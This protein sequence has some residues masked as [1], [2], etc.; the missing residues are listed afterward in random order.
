MFHVRISPQQRI[1]EC[2]EPGEVELSRQAR[3]LQRHARNGVEYV[4][5]MQQLLHLFSDAYRVTYRFE[6]ALRLCQD[7]AQYPGYRLLLDER[8]R[9]LKHQFSAAKCF[10][11][12]Y[13]L[14][15]QLRVERS[16]EVR[17]HLRL[18]ESLCLHRQLAYHSRGIDH[19]Q[20]CIELRRA[21]I[22]DQAEWAANED[23]QH[24]VNQYRE[25][26]QRIQLQITQDR[27]VLE[28]EWRQ[29]HSA[30]ESH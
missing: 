12:W 25:N 21:L 16:P 17:W 4:V 13:R 19:R 2:P 3:H 1:L 30:M 8:L 14:Q 6:L 24:H 26:L 11:F 7:R 9:E 10:M 18:L 15:H 27:Q 28:A 23:S 20:R 29:Q 22:T 5:A